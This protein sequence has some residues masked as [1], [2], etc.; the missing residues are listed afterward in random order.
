MSYQQHILGAQHLQIRLLT[1]LQFRSQT[2]AKQQQRNCHAL[3]AEKKST[4]SG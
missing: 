4:L 1:M 3:P 2:A